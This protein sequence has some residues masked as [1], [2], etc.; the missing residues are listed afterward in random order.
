MR[1]TTTRGADSG[2]ESSKKAILGMVAIARSR[3]EEIE[4]L[5]E[6]LRSA[7]ERFDAERLIAAPD[8]GLSLLGRDLARAKLQVLTEAAHSL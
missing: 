1:T 4:Q 8:C 6:R 2:F 3:S 7:Q 5:R